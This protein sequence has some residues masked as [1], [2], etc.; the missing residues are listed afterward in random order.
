[1]SDLDPMDQD[2][3][4]LRLQILCYCIGVS[5]HHKKAVDSYVEDHHMARSQHRLLLT[6]SKM[7]DNV[8]QK[9]LAKQM[10]VTPAAVAVTLRKLEAAD[11]IEKKTSQK[12]N[13]YNRVVIT[14]LGKQIVSD[15]EKAFRS[16][17]E[18]CFE[19]FSTQD[20]KMMLDFLSRMDENL[21]RITEKKKR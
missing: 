21:S 19:G 2:E 11:I 6:L 9:D 13:R 4:S 8:C 5:K 14:D 16:I 15:S 3:A 1:M 7:G 12:D 17:D 20:L 18:R 10:Q